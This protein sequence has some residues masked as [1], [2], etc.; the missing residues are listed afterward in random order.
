M[1]DRK[2]SLCITNYNRYE[3]LFESFAQVA[4]DDRVGEIVIS[5]DFSTK[6]V[7]E[8]AAKAAA[9]PKVKLYHNDTNLGCYA[10]KREAIDRATNEYVII[11]DSDNVIDGYYLDKIFSQTWHPEV[12]LAPDYAFP[13]DYRTF[14]DLTFNRSNVAQWVD[15]PG[16]DSLMNTMNYFVHRDNFLEV[17][18]PELYIK[19]ADSIYFNCLWFEAGYSVH[20]LK[21]LQYFHRLEHDKEQGSHYLQYAVGSAPRCGQILEAMGRMK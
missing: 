17:Y 1:D 6:F 11:F 19:G 4:N 15:H 2:V 18:R 16:F 9:F 5:D 13:L 14:T 8:V 20:V 3:Y 7:Q 10:N 12:V 21:G